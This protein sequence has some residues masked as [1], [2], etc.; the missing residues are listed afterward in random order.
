M[1]HKEVSQLWRQK[2][3]RSDRRGIGTQIGKAKTT[4]ESKS[5]NPLVFLTKT[6][7]R[8]PSAKTRKSAKHNKH[9][10]CETEVCLV[11]NWKTDLP[12]TNTAK[13]KILIPLPYWYYSSTEELLREDHAKWLQIAKRGLTS[14]TEA[15]CYLCIERLHFD[16]PYFP[17]ITCV[18]SWALPCRV[19]NF[20]RWKNCVHPPFQSLSNLYMNNWP[21]ISS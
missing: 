2:D 8:K 15:Q 16:C 18:N 17:G 13:P 12:P 4:L 9:Q 11:Q 20:E 6:E 7:N 3:C 5:E 14:F 19:S 21:N 10:N 1:E